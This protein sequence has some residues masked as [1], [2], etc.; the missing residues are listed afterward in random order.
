MNQMIMEEDLKH[1]GVDVNNPEQPRK[2]LQFEPWIKENIDLLQSVDV[3]ERD[4]VDQID[5]FYSKPDFPSN[6]FEEFKEEIPDENLLEKSN[7]AKLT[8][9]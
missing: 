1:D 2:E 9:I 5:L 8:A 4:M 3:E 6:K 7:Q